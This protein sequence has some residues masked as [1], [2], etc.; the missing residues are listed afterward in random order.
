MLS[1]IAL[2][3]PPVAV[4]SASTGPG[5][6][7]IVPE[8]WASTAE[9]LHYSPAVKAGGM[10]YLSGVVAS[11]PG[12]AVGG[13]LPDQ[14]AQ[15]AAYAAAFDAIGTILAE[16]GTDWDRVVKITTYH[17][18]LPAQIG[19]FAAVKDRYVR[20]PYPAWTA[21]EIDRLYTNQGLV[22]IEITAM[23]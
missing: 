10:V 18:D 7:M 9:S 13:D 8:A 21:V 14:E 23:E 4:P 20:A 15:E 2:L 19:P 16:A 1:L 12:Y 6:E 5:P 17:T 3:A 11:D 22:E